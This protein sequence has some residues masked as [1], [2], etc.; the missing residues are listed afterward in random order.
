MQ[1]S[2]SDRRFVDEVLAEPGGENLF[3]CYACGTC[4]GTCLVTRVNP[5]FNPRRILKMVMLG[6][7]EDVLASPFI[8]LCSACDL[9]Y[10]LC[11][12]EIHISAL[13]RAIRNIAIREGYRPPGP[14]AT[15]QSE[16]CSGCGQCATACPYDAISLVAAPTPGNGHGER[17]IAQVDDFLCMNCGICAATCPSGAIDVGD[18]TREQLAMRIQAN[19]WLQSERRPRVVLFGCEW[20]QRAMDD[21]NALE[22]LPHIRILPIPCTGQLDHALVLAALVSGVDGVLVVGCAPGECHY[23]R[24][25]LLARRRILEIGPLLKAV[26]I[27]SERLRVVWISRSERKRVQ[28]EVETFAAAIERLGPTPVLAPERRRS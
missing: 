21:L 1:E 20:N 7:R 12:Q 2:D 6:M 13:M 24:G 16:R 19:G 9:C 26:G 5:R 11:P 27:G 28:A 3:R 22:P 18:S 10:P 4:A 25:N 23:T 14:A 17:V 15:V 8:W